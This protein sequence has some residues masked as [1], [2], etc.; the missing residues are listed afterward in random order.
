[1]VS[2]KNPAI[3][4]PFGQPIYNPEE[5]SV[6]LAVCLECQLATNEPNK[7]DWEEDSDDFIRLSVTVLPEPTTKEEVTER[8]LALLPRSAPGLDGISTA[9]L[10]RL[11]GRGICFLTELFN[12]CLRHCYFPRQWSN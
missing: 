11:P 9:A 6:Y 8:L 12:V 2:P 5:K 7:W 4:E 3:A 1:M 10:K